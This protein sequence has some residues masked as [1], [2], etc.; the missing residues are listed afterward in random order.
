MITP[1]NSIMLAC[2]SDA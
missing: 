1:S 2:L